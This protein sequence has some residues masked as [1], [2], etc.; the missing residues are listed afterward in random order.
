MT[1][2]TTRSDAAQTPKEVGDVG[3]RNKK[4]NQEGEKPRP[5]TPPDPKD[6]S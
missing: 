2:N 3:E 4:L 5:T 1:Q 6:R